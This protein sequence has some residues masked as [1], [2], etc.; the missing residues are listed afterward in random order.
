MSRIKYE[1]FDTE[2]E[3]ISFDANGD[4]ALELILPRELDGFISID[5]VVTRLTDGVARYDLRYIADGEYA[6]QLVLRRGRI[7]LPKLKKCGRVISLSECDGDY[8]RST[9][10]RERR[11]AARVKALEEEIEL[12]KK[13]IYGTKIL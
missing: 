6:P 2:A 1:I 8:M 13:C 5:G 9:S 3:V 12:L 7:V 10:I 4:T 11:L